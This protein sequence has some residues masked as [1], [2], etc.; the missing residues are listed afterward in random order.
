MPIGSID[1]T[2]TAPW[3]DPYNA[4]PA[5]TQ[6]MLSAYFPG[7]ATVATTVFNLTGFDPMHGIVN[8]DGNGT[9]GYENDL[10]QVMI[11]Y[12]GYDALGNDWHL[13]IEQQ[14]S[15]DSTNYEYREHGWVFMRGPYNDQIYVCTTQES[16]EQPYNLPYKQP[17]NAVDSLGNVWLNQPGGTLYIQPILTSVAPW[18]RRRRRLLE[19]CP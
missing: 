10:W 14:N 4:W 13:L 12:V 1:Y 6:V 3:N 7:D 16:P 8:W 15:A 11:D 9:P 2:S 18:E 17:D 19:L 5:C